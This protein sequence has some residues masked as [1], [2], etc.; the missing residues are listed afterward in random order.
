M[1]RSA[2]VGLLVTALA[3]P[4]T[5]ACSA[6]YA[7]ETVLFKPAPDWVIDA[8]GLSAPEKAAE[9]LIRFDRQQKVDD[10]LVVTYVDL[11]ERASSTEQLAG[12]G[13]IKL[14]WH[15]DKGDMTIHHIDILRG[16]EVIDITK[17]GAKFTI[18]RREQGLES[19]A[20]DGILT[21]TLQV[22]GLKVG[23]LLRITSST[24]FRDTALAGH[25]QVNQRLFPEPFKVARSSYRMIWPHGST[26]KW[27]VSPS[28]VQPVI[29][30]IGKYDE[31]TIAQPI[32]KL[33]DSPA[34]APLRFAPPPLFEASDFANWADV[35][36]ASLPLYATEGLIPKGS[37]LAE[38]IAQIAAKSSD[39]KTRA[40]AALRVVQDDIRYLANGQKE[41]N[42][43]PQ[44]P[45]ETWTK[46]YGDCKAKT[47]LLVSMLRA[48]GIQ[49]DAAY[50]SI[51]YGD[52]I[53]SRLPAI[54]PFNHAITRAVI[55][56]KIYWLDGTALGTRQIDMADPLPYRAILPIRADTVTLENIPFAAPARPH[57]S[58]ENTIDMSAGIELPHPFKAMITIHGGEVYG[59]RKS[60][61]SL[62]PKKFDDMVDRFVA[63]PGSQ[64]TQRSIRF[65]DDAATATITAEGIQ[66]APWKTENEHRLIK[67][68]SIAKGIAL[69]W[70]R[71]RPEWKGAAVSVANLN[72]VESHLRLILPHNGTPFKIENLKSALDHVGGYEVGFGAHYTAPVLV[73]DHSI[74]ASALEIPSASLF[75][76]REKLARVLAEPLRIIAPADY[77]PAWKEARL[78]R[79][80]GRIKQIET[81]YATIIAHDEANEFKGTLS[82]AAFRIFVDDKVGAI[83]DLSTVIAKKPTVQLY[84][85]RASL[86]RL[87][88][89]QKAIADIK[90]AR[91]SEPTSESAIAL[92]TQIYDAQRAYPAALAVLDAALPLQ[93]NKANL[94]VLKAE[95]LVQSGKVT[96]GLSILNQANDEKPGNVTLLN[97]RCW[98]RAIANTELDLALKDCTKAIELADHP[99]VV[100]DSRGFVYY[101]LG[102]FDEAIAD[103]DAAIKLN[104]AEAN[105][106][107]VRGLAR[108]AKGL[109]TGAQDIADARLLKPDVEAE[110]ARYGL[111]VKP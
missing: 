95:M 9:G 75:D 98:V 96:D 21:A 65:D 26:L 18:L 71:S 63:L 31:L 80:E 15:P 103:L 42:Y 51:G 70:D 24:T 76:E 55:D 108:T 48:L 82:R 39:P 68:E 7:G 8:G 60:Q 89:P 3:L 20:I 1:K 30:R 28:T 66:S 49:A 46:R 87:L 59:L 109:T 19:Q 64:I 22:E 33:P 52:L 84:L 58:S 104:P 81:A 79:A 83:A 99:A 57:F 102:R 97:G 54:A 86:Y 110:Y 85:T 25:V 38:Q 50:A 27:R 6:S 17:S 12:L 40:A 44:T 32:P 78:A 11:I 45:T 13:T 36:K 34:N 14:E 23:D 5:L 74:K 56:G 43:T 29:T 10:G 37:P 53:P 105:S 35:A 16:A 100:L 101:R 111:K 77:P 93:E 47:L 88:D 69:G 62:E 72:F 2:R 107:F 94:Q 61:S 90:L 41:G 73:V 91:A 67:I 106:L 92:L 4:A